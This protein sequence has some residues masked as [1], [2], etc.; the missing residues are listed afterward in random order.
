MKHGTDRQVMPSIDLIHPGHVER[1]KFALSRVKGFV[2]DAACG[3]GYGSWLM[4]SVAD[5]TGI[6]IEPEA[7][8]YAQTYYAGPTYEVD[9][10]QIEQ[11]SFDWVV[12]LETIEHLTN[13]EKAL[14]AFRDS[15]RLII[16]TPN[17]LEFP[18][19][20]A[21]HIDSK[22]PHLRHYTPD[23]F[24]TLLND[25]G[26]TVIEK[27]GQKTKTSPVTRGTGKFLVWVCE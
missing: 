8:E 27:M 25:N 21:D 10:A 11:G 16:S 15:D 20:P 2:L 19:V 3:V 6:D 9:D 24:E 18:F 13:P 7:I 1:Y 26:W 5:V 12:S 22:Y 17:E 23:S 14:H 4:Q